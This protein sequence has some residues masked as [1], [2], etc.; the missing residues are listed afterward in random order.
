MN[1]HEL[2]KISM[3]SAGGFEINTFEQIK[4]FRIFNF[5]GKQ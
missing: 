1:V 4:L 3:T 2:T 5:R